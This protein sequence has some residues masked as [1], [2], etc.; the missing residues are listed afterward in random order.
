MNGGVT[1]PPRRERRAFGR[2]RSCLREPVARKRDRSLRMRSADTKAQPLA[3]PA[4]EGNASNA[5]E[6]E[7]RAP[8]RC[9]A[10]AAATGKRGN[11]VA[12]AIASGYSERLARVSTWSSSASAWSISAPEMCSDG[13]RVITFL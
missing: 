8:L 10:T 3:R 9:D 5:S 12:A 4:G 7:G 6:G 2:S 1:S 13:A 11:T